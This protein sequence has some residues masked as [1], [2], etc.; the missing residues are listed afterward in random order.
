[1]LSGLFQ[2]TTIPVLQEAVN[3]AQA[4][5]TVLAGNIANFL[6]ESE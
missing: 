2:S 1:M 4:R 3:F 6:P 5:H